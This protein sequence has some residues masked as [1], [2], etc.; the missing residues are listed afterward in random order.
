MCPYAHML[1][2]VTGR[3]ILVPPVGPDGKFIAEVVGKSGKV[4]KAAVDEETLK[5]KEVHRRGWYMIAACIGVE[6]GDVGSCG[7][8]AVV[9]RFP[10]GCKHLLI[11]SIHQPNFFVFTYLQ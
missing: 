3:A 1:D 6:V 8:V 4:K 5:K 11:L 9:A 10:G 7:S 2:K